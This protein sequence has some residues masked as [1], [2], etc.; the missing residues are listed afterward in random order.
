[1][2][3]IK[4]THLAIKYVIVSWDRSLTKLIFWFLGVGCASYVQPSLE[5]SIRW[6]RT[7]RYS[8]FHL[9]WQ[10]WIYLLTSFTAL[11]KGPIVAMIVVI[12]SMT[13]R[14]CIIIARSC[15]GM[16]QGGEGRDKLANPRGHERMMDDCGIVRSSYLS[17]RHL[18]LK[19]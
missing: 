16:Y 11:V 18:R 1:M 6:Q 12:I 4:V 13:P 7:G 3:H 14:N 15:T 10:L 5:A 2:R 9:K 17:S 8:M 19:L